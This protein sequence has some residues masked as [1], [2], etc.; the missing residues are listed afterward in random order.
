MTS[1]ARG[2]TR[3]AML[4]PDLRGGGAERVGIDLANEFVRRAL[5]VD[6]LLMRAE[7]DLFS[8]LD[9]R[10]RVVN[11]NASRTRNALAPI[12]SYL[13]TERPS[14]LIANMW[15]LTVLAPV[16]RQ[17]S[18]SCCKILV[19]EHAAIS[20]QYEE[21]GS[22]HKHALS[23]SLALGVRLADERAGVSQGVA[24]DLARLAHF[25]KEKIATLYNPIPIQTNVSEHAL[26]YANNIWGCPKGRRVIAVGSLKKQKNHAMLLRAFC[27]MDDDQAF[28]LI[29]GQGSL[30]VELRALAVELGI[31][32]RVRFAGFH[33][34][35]T[36]FYRSAD[37][38]VL[39]SDYEGF[40]NVIVE[41]LGQGI[42]VVS[43]ECP[44]GPSEILQ[45]G[46]YGALVP[47]GD[48]NALANAMQDML[49]RQHDTQA[50]KRR[51]HDFSVDKAANA[52]LDLLLPT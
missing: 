1:E 28:L 6:M 42:P 47:I 41:A 22:F 19:V 27:A 32:E 46:R 14:A 3:I 40:G 49:S 33:H 12:Y 10:V 20:Q 2:L 29:L 16:A 21:W 31:A 4:L 43:T 17:F 11:L 34:D 25:P 5:S 26:A 8:Q 48:V 23:A 9:N 15:P 50:L 35:P 24:E 36:P 7:G 44:S 18:R 39:S 51:A 38:F 37:L 45:N 13:R 52:Y 30:E